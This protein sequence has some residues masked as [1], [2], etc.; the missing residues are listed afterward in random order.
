METSYTHTRTRTQGHRETR[1][2][3]HAEVALRVCSYLCVCGQCGPSFQSEV[4]PSHSAAFEGNWDQHWAYFLGHEDENAD[5]RSLQPFRLTLYKQRVFM[6][7]RL[8]REEVQLLGTHKSP[9]KNV[10]RVVE[11]L[12]RMDPLSE[13]KWSVNENWDDL[14]EVTA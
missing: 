6:P 2:R 13:K 11:F 5:P 9:M 4:S 14:K 8:L 10:A 3:T 1:A 12:L 7:Y